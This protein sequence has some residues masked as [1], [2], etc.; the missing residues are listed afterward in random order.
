MYLKEHTQ[1]QKTTASG[2]P[3]SSRENVNFILVKTKE[4]DTTLKNQQ[5]T[6]TGLLLTEMLLRSPP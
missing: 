3:A 2:E 1:R 6:M 4:N 5:W